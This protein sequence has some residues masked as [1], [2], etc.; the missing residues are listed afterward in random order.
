[1]MGSERSSE[2]ANG[3]M[4]EVLFPFEAKYHNLNQ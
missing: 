3:G 2:L 1:M 4:V